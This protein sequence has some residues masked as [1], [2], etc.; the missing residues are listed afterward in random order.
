LN[1]RQI[2][3]QSLKFTGIFTAPLHSVQPGLQARRRNS[4]L[5]PPQRHATFDEA[6]APIAAVQ[7]R[8]KTCAR[9]NFRTLYFSSSNG[10][11]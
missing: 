8:R 11:Q 6:G 3:A 4:I 5:D 10:L 7:H 2:H 1:F 9:Y